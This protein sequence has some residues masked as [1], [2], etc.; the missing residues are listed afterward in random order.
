MT[1]F[2]VILSS[3]SGGG[4]TTIARRILAART[5]V[6]YSIS[7]TT[8]PRREDEQ[9]G[10]DYHF[11]SVVDFEAKRGAGEFA[12]CALVHG[13]WYGTLRAEVDRVLGSNRHVLMAIDVQGARQFSG[14]Y[15]S[16]VLV[17]LLPP[18]V[19]AL[20]ARLRGRNTESAESIARRLRT[21]LT[22]MEAIG[23]YEYVVVNDSL[24]AATY[25]VSAIIDAEAV[26]LRRRNGVNATVTG[27]IS[28]LRRAVA[29]YNPQE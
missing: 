23:E 5:D 6:G 22:E 12:E 27:L 16:S 8:R 26:R 2:P 17:F 11:L 25:A 3:P 14:V 1:P 15:P 28:D 7:A 13:Q 29:T 20:I 21:A 4:K 24:E 18:S 10:V 9:E 19:D